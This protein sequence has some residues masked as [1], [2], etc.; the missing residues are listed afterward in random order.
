MRVC[1]FCC[2]IRICISVGVVC[3]CCFG[4]FIGVSAD[5]IHSDDVG[6]NIFHTGV[7][8]GVGLWKSVCV[9]LLRIPRLI[10]RVLSACREVRM[11]LTP[12]VSPKLP[13]L[14]AGYMFLLTLL[15]A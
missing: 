2:C 8:E 3:N 6:I 4:L 9:S 12:F 10:L 7:S 5:A 13:S 1:W 14:S 15:N 11:D